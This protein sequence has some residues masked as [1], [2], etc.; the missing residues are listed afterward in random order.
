[1][2]NNYYGVNTRHTWPERMALKQV[3][4]LERTVRR[5]GEGAGR[6]RSHANISYPLCDLDNF[7]EE[8]EGTPTN[9]QICIFKCL[10]TNIFRLYD[11]VLVRHQT[12]QL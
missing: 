10:C 3:Q 1:M 8:T 2:Y 9:D 12:G 6:H 4:L 5:L 7:Y 11:K